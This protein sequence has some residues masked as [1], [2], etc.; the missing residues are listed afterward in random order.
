MTTDATEIEPVEGEI[1]VSE[2]GNSSL[3]AF[4]SLY[5]PDLDFRKLASEAQ[6]F[7]RGFRLVDKDELIGIPHVV[8]AVTYREGYLRDKVQGDYVSIE[9]VVADAETLNS[10]QVRKMAGDAISVY[11]NEAVV[12]NDGGTGIRRKFTEDFHNMGLINVGGKLD[13]ER[14][15]DRPYSQW[16]NGAGLAQS[17]IV[18]DRDGQKYRMISLRGLRRS[19]YESPFGPATTFYYA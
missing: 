12:Y 13:D 2:A 15:F 4:R 6:Y 8:I 7:T 14:R 10:S 3:A 5:D 11:P 16:S 17:G 19:D 18:A 1:A 9:A